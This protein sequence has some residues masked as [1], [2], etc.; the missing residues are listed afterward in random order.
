MEINKLR[1]EIQYMK[2]RTLSLTVTH[3][4]R[5]LVKAPIRTPEKYVLDFV[6]SKS[7]WIQ[8]K[9]AQASQSQQ[10]V[11]GL[12]LENLDI[13]KQKKLAKLMVV[14]KIK[15][16]SE[17]MQLSYRSVRLSSARTRW[18]SCTHQNTISINW[19]LSLLPSELMDYVIIHELAHVKEKNHSSKFWDIV[20]KDCDDYKL[21][22]KKL[23]GFGRILQLV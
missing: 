10:S 13:L 20:K 11:E 2:R 9:I 16:W 6:Q 21:L 22:R 15:Y 14:E 12:D 5:L 7:S 3:E 4:G 1:V 18:G 23:K 17:K 8:R 19:R